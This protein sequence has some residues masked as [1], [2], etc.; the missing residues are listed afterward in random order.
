M[1]MSMFEVRKVD[2][3]EQCSQTTL[4]RVFFT[5]YLQALQINGKSAL[6]WQE[7]LALSNMSVYDLP[8]YVCVC[9]CIHD[10]LSLSF[11]KLLH[12]PP[13]SALLLVIVSLFQMFNLYAVTSNSTCFCP[14]PFLYFS[15]SGVA[16]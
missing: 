16:S 14:S 3:T 4:V 15:H 7:K 10:L 8:L 9:V 13:L 12:E 5:I 2:F 11:H 6:S 1:I